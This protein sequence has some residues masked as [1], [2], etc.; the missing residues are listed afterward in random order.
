MDKTKRILKYIG[1]FSIIQIL[2]ITNGVLYFLIPLLTVQLN[3]FHTSIQPPTLNRF[4]SMHT[5]FHCE[6]ITHKHP[7][8]KTNCL[9][10]SQCFNSFSSIWHGQNNAPTKRGSYVFVFHQL[11]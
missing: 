11:I 4:I 9:Y 8:K 1:C 3:D 10:L 7:F 2:F 6:K 5:V